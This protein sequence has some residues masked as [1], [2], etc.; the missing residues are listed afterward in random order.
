M[1]RSG[2]RVRQLRIARA[3]RSQ[4]PAVTSSQ[5]LEIFLSYIL[6]VFA[7]I[8]IGMRGDHHEKRIEDLNRRLEKL[9]SRR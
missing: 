2:R 4:A 9:E 5:A 3:Q 7:V 6:L 8:G 1:D